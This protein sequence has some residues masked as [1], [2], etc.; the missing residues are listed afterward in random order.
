MRVLLPAV[1]CC[2]LVSTETV[3][4]AQQA[5]N[6]SIAPVV[7]DCWPKTGSVNSVIELK[8]FRLGAG[9]KESAKAF[10]IQNGLEIAARTGGGS[11]VTN[12]SLNGAQTLEVILPEEVVVGPAKIVV[13]RDGVRSTPILITITEWTL[14]VIKSISP[15]SGPPG[16]FVNI[17]CDNFHINDEIE[18]TD[19]EGRVVKQHESGGS[20]NGT[21]FGVPKDFPEGVLRIRI[22]SRK[23]G[24][25]QF[26][27]PVEFTVTNEPG[28]LE[29]S[30]DWII[31][32]APGQWIDLQSSTLSVLK[33]SERTEVSYTQAGR[34]IMVS[35]PNPHRPHIEVPS[36]LSPGVVQV[37][38]R[39]W[40]HGRASAWSKALLQLPDKPVPSDVQA[41]RLEKGSWVQLWPGP[42]RA[43]RFEAT[44]GDSVV[45]NG[46]FH[47]A[48][49][50]KLKVLL[51]RSGESLELTVTELDQKADWFHEVILKLPDD[52]GAGDWQMVLH[53]VDDGTEFQVPIPIRILP[54][55]IIQGFP[56]D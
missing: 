19:Q 34:T 49:A 4:R 41:L 15:E 38:A 7:T 8:G 46:R 9:D 54:V 31:P 1:L 37:Q 36:A 12:D 29:L 23:A 14:P 2:L 16:T 30:T 26:T 52:L 20:S 48:D 35:A 33:N 50:Q 47:V 13:E 40:R 43:E 10:I 5:A 51:M 55:A 27:S 18:L 28:S 45:I 6:S 24:R 17:E 39:T 56:L 11:S 42:D 25:N 53:S 21:G 32:V 3:M 44:P 22:G